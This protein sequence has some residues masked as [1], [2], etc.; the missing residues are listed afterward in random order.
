ME[1]APCWE[2]PHALEEY[3]IVRRLGGGSM[4]QVYLAHD[5]LLD[6]PVA[7]KFAGMGEVGEAT[8]ERFF[9][10][11]R[12][13][14]RLSHPNIVAVHRFGEVRRRPYLVS[15]YVRGPSLDRLDKPLPWRRLHKIGLGLARGLAWAHENGVLHCDVKPAN[16][17]LGDGDEAKLIDFGLARL[18]DAD[19]PPSAT[20][21]AA[22]ACP[23]TDESPVTAT[24]T[25][26]YRPP[27][28]RGDG[29]PA[30][31]SGTP[32]TA[33]P[34]R[35]AFPMTAGTPLYLAPELWRGEPATRR[36]DV[37]ALGVLLYELA[38]GAAP[39]DGVSI[40]RLSVLVEEE[41]AAPIASRAPSLPAELAGLI[42][43]C[44]SRDPARRPRLDGALCE[45]LAAL[46]PRPG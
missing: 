39:H 24:M 15:E 28:R 42:D 22:I 10:E 3:R 44:L 23:L 26:P 1:S 25:M 9:A 29:A 21:A 43:A 46:A 6:R 2:P 12:A 37:Y 13:V 16:A 19:P 34:R 33:G 17:M 40:D 5:R 32:P 11:A 20:H 45:Q 18:L 38:S 35:S 41:A 36:S 8:R 31:A 30:T 27:G 14:A 7:I 4:G